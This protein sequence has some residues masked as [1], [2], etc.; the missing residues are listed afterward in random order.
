[1]VAS[2]A[3]VVFYDHRSG[4]C[5]DYLTV[6]VDAEG[7]L[8]VRLYHGKGA[9]GPAP[10]DRVDDLYEVCG[11]ATKCVQWRSKK[12]LVSHVKT[13]LRTGSCFQKGDLPS[14][15]TLV[16]P[17]IR[18][19]FSLE[20]YAMQPGV[21]KSQLSPKMATLLATTNRGLVSVG[22][23]RLRVICSPKSSCSLDGPAQRVELYGRARYRPAHPR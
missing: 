4:E 21:S 7:E 23:Q 15:L 14:F 2:D 1:L 9:G 12:R 16:E 20:V 18:Y 19:Q 3:L 8:L 17:Y 13:R 5:A 11:Q 22:C 6:S 10:G